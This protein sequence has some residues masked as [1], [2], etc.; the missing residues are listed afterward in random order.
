MSAGETKRGRSV[1][2]R[3]DAR[4]LSVK[5]LVNE[6]AQNEQILRRYQQFELQMLANGSLEAVLSTLLETSITAL[7]LDATELWLCDAQDS[8]TEMLPEAFAAHPGLQLLKHE[9]SFERLYE[10]QPVVRLVS[11]KD[12]TTLP[13]FKG[14][15]LRSAAMLPLYR[16]NSFVGSMHFGAKT[17]R[18]FTA[19]K[20]TDFMQHLA[21]I[22]AVCIENAISQEHLRRLSMLDMLTRVNNRHGFDLALDKEV[23][24]AARSGAPLSLLFVDLD[25]F[26]A[27]NDNYGHPLGDKVLRAVAQLLKDTLRRVDHV[28]RY[29]GEEFAL[30]LPD[31]RRELA[32]DIAE[33]LRLRVS[34]LRIDI[35][36]ES[37]N[38]EGGAINT[39]LSMGVCCWEPTR[40][41][42]KINET[43]IARE[44]IQRSDQGV[45]E[46][47]ASGRNSVCYVAFSAL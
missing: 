32:M 27:I 31:C 1:E 6:A 11:I 15:D 29:G 28:C 45:Y 21:S 44:L 30:V 2:R 19:K 9:R 22:I 33:R 14:R 17:E 46:A 13:V 12:T 34:Q 35:D 43:K 37:D 25:H 38:N 23:S 42:H 7:R 39:T 5:Q 40:G 10:A 26:K 8:L 36:E 3:S 24:R 41:R 18:R 20:S 47:K 4:A 16:N